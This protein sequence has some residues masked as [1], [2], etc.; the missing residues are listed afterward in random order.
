MPLQNQDIANDFEKLADLIEIAGANRFRVRAYRNAAATL[1]GLERPVRQMVDAGEDLSALPDIGDDL[2]GQIREYAHTGHLAKL[3]Q[4]SETLPPRI[5]TLLDLPG[6]G[7]KRVHALHEG[8]GVCDRDDLAQAARAGR[9]RELSGFGE[10]LEA[11]ILQALSREANAPAARMLL[12]TAEASAEP[13]LAWLRSLAGVEKASIAGSYRR[14]RD[15][16]GDL[17]IVVTARDAAAVSAAVT[18]YEAVAEVRSSGETRSTVVLRNGLQVDIR[19]MPA[20]SYGAAM[21]YFTGSR[22]H[23]IALRRRAQQRDLK[24]NEYG[25]F[26][27]D[28]AIAGRTEAEVYQALSLPWIAPELRENRGEIAAAEAGTLPALVTPEAIRGNLHTHTT[29]SDGKAGLTQMVRAAVDRGWA[30]LG[31]S[32]HSQALRMAN[33]LDAKR[34]GEQME[35]IDRLNDDDPGLLVLKSCEVDILRDGRL[36]LPDAVLERLDYV[37]AA[38]HSDLG[39]DRKAQTRRILRAMENPRVTILAHPTGRLINRR[40]PMAL[41]ME[42][43]CRAAADQ[44]VVLEVNAQPQRLDLDDRDIMMA[45]EAGARLSI[46]TDAH[47]PDHY[48]YMRYGV[49]QARRGWASADAIINTLSPT[50]LRRVLAARR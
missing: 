38:V 15:T 17:D 30:Y 18:G 13:L 41:D 34:L 8:L 28:E 40:Q 19:V 44:G 37:I 20:R 31:I 29:A 24:L 23:N 46:G 11:R 25:V 1:R 42:A 32:D 2:A 33:G 9:V 10:K 5:I 22:A 35:A 39:L 47:M 45:L 48:D 27:G 4:A 3:D 16:V 7:P 12:A 26:R 43:I 49:D 50:A 6:L 36:D 21:H 14:R